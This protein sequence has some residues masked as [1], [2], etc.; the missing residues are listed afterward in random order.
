MDNAPATLR[1]GYVHIFFE[2]ADQFWR[3]APSDLYDR[4]E[5]AIRHRYVLYG[6]PVEQID[7]LI[8][9]SSDWLE[10]FRIV[11]LGAELSLQRGN[12]TYRDRV[13]VLFEDENIGWRLGRDGLLTHAVSAEFTAATAAAAAAT[14]RPE[15]THLRDQLTSAMDKLKQRNFDP[16]NA[17]KD[18]V[19]AL[20][21]VARWRFGKTTGDLGDMARE[22]KSAI[23]PALGG[24]IDSLLKIEAY[25]G[26]MAAHA[27]KADRTVTHEEAIFVI[28]ECSAAISLLAT[29]PVE[30]GRS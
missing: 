23:H 24:A 18:A 2:V 9:Q 27:D 14:N 15:L 19:G 6:P 29:E 5:Q 17:A 16:K 26:D 4:C 20:E 30:R 10:F 22:L 7:K 13:N 28:H 21:G 1:T 12:S 11:E 3:I 8:L 25:R